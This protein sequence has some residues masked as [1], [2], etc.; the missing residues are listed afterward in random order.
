MVSGLTI[1]RLAKMAGVTVQTV[2]YYERRNL[3]QPTDRKASGYRIYGDDAL[4]RLRF[5]KNAQ[6]LGFTLREVN[7]LLN[8]RV[9]SVAQCVA[10]QV[11]A[12]AK[13]RQVEAKARDLLALSRALKSLI[14]A[15]RAGQ[16]TAHCPILVSLE[17]GQEGFTRSEQKA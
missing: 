1:G 13:L 6:A 2:R 11:K 10:V 7:D 4:R 5:I 14:R 16:P 15:C 3:L 17:D 8:L 12:Q 9:S